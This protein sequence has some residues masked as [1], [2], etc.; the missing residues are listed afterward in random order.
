M[1]TELRDLDLSAALLVI[2]RMRAMDRACL[3][4][5]L[6]GFSDEQFA[7]NRWQTDGPAWALVQDGEP[8]AIGGISFTNAWT[9]VFWLIAT[10]AMR[11]KQWEF[12]IRTLDN[13]L[14]RAQDP[15]NP[16]YRRRL[17]AYTLR[18]WPQACR[19]AASRFE[20]EGVKRGAGAS[21]EDIVTWA[22]VAQ[23][24]NRGTA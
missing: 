22:R 14:A 8:V 15:T 24:K 19:F 12:A 4:A 1:S 21:G 16:A 9:G 7:V 3:Q 23:E 5:L 20:C 18:D 2:S 6:P 17:E 10:D 13:V 11:R